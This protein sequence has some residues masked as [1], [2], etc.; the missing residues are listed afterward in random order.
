MSQVYYHVCPH[1]RTQLSISHLP[2]EKTV[3][4]CPQCGMYIVLDNYGKDTRKPHVYK[5]PKCKEPQIYDGRPPFVKCSKCSNLYVTSAHGEGMIDIDLLAKGNKGELPYKKKKDKYIATLNIWYGL[6][7]KMKTVVISSAVAVLALIAGIYYLSLPDAIDTTQAYAN[8]DAVWNEFS[9]SNPY[10]IQLECIRNYDDNSRLVILS[11]PSDFVSEEE[12]DEFFGKYNSYTKTY[13]RKIGFDGWMRDYVVAFNDLD[14]DDYNSFVKKLSMLLYKTDYKAELID[15][16]VMVSHTPYLDSTLNYNVTTEELKEW[17]IDNAEPIMPLEGGSGIATD[18]KS[19]LSGTIENGMQLYSSVAPGF[20]IWTI[21]QTN[22]LPELDFRIFAR[23]FSLDSD[24]ILGAIAKDDNIAI[25]ARERC[26]PITQLPPMRAET[27]CLL[28]NTRD[29]ELSQSYER[30][31]LFAGKQTGDA[32][33]GKDFAPIL[34][35]DALWHTEYGNILNVTDQM[36]KSWSENGMIDYVDFN[37]PKPVFWTFEKGAIRDLDVLTL[38]YN[39]NTEGVGYIVDDNDYAVYALNRTGSLPVS[40]I[41][42]DAKQTTEK[43]P[44]YQAEQKAYDFF[45]SLSNP[46][47]LKVVQY[48]SMYQIFQN[49]GVHMAYDNIQ[50]YDDIKFVMSSNLQLETGKMLKKIANYSSEDRDSIARYYNAHVVTGNEEGISL[51]N[52]Y[53]LV[54]N[55]PNLPKDEFGISLYSIF[56]YKLDPAEQTDLM[57]LIYASKLMLE[58][59]TLHMYLSRVATDKVFMESLANAL[60]DR[61]EIDNIRYSD[62]I[63][64]QYGIDSNIKIR[65]KEDEVGDAF[66]AVFSKEKYL[67]NYIEIFS[68]YSHN[69]AKKLMVQANAHRNRTWMKTP[70]VVESWSLV[71]SIYQEGGHNLNSKVTRFRV[72]DDLKPGQTRTVSSGGKNIIEVSRAD[73]RSHITSQSYLRRVGRLDDAT[74]KGSAVETRPRSLVGDA[75]SNRSARGFNKEDHTMVI[76]KSLFKYGEK[77]YKSLD[78]LLADF[79]RTSS[80]E[81]VLE[82]RIQCLEG[83]GV[84]Q[85]MIINGIHSHLNR[86]NTMLPMSKFDFLHATQTASD[87]GVTYTIPIKPGML[88]MGST[89][90]L[91]KAGMGGSSDVGVRI[92][93]LEGNI[94]FKIVNQSKMSKILAVLKDFFKNGKNFFNEYKLKS[95]L[96][97]HGIEVGKDIETSIHLK[98]NKEGVKESDY[99][100]VAVVNLKN[101][102]IYAVQL[103]KKEEKI[104]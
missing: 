94:S 54:S 56:M 103:F 71:D 88:E 90:G 102:C 76:G 16:S 79:C 27:L 72:A 40:Y 78:M 49:F 51:G 28:A 13:K 65:S 84:T 32:Y 50:D 18:M 1:C 9:E 38:T 83:A 23:K 30:N 104:A 74:I 15:M 41:P 12:L 98:V 61:N 57:N 68:A 100:M 92:N 25:I 62:D 91:N 17:F 64:L 3:S 19:V 101:D 69:K 37:Y 26:I 85:K 95:V 48:A 29:D 87:G 89:S 86:G 45:S 52:G 96:K 10:N 97:Q 59:D 36:L 63:R 35:S 82:L 33:G 80:P 55:N 67:K 73:S 24:I 4:K 46:E 6:S 43:D 2:V 58:V 5:C 42:G 75:A 21:D 99:I 44:V 53:S 39:W 34:L 7:S 20:V 60:L 70:T 81:E 8:M 93:V 66:N 14:D 77:E 11:E 31:N 47:L 22:S